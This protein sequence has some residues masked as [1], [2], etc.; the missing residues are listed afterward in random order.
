MYRES[1]VTLVTVIDQHQ[2]GVTRSDVVRERTATLIVKTC[3][4]PQFT[5][6]NGAVSG[7]ARRTPDLEQIL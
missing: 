4:R 2:H 6:P 1:V 5:S 3:L 7:R